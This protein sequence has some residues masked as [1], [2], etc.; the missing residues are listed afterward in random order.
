[1]SFSADDFAKALEQESYDFR[2]GQIVRGKVFEYES[3]GAYVD[4][5]GKSPAFL[6]KSEAALTPVENLSE[7]L[8]KGEE[9]EFAI[10]SQPNAEGQ[11]K[12]SLRQLELLKVWDELSEKQRLN[13]SV[14]V[15]VNGVNKGGVTVDIGGLRGFIPRSH[16]LQRGDL[17]GLVG[18]KLSVSFLELDRDREKLVLSQRLVA[19]A[20]R[21]EALQVGQ[22]VE[23]EV[24]GIKPFGVFVDLDGVT[25]LLHINQVSNKY[26]RALDELFHI[27]QGISAIAIDI[28]EYKGRISLSTKLLENYPGE[29]LEQFDQVMAEAPARREKVGEKILPE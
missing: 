16:L 23:G 11:V 5:G 4:I 12:V 1:M 24:V 6:P 25:A 22:L 13:Q 20:S 9:R 21:M 15:R 3:N 2:P 10:V 7:F 19:Q 14:E 17:Q 26:V 29:I 8:P 18:Q 27:G 28:D